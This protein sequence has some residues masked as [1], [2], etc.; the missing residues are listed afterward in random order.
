MYVVYELVIS[1]KSICSVYICHVSMLYQAALHSLYLYLF[2]LFPRYPVIDSDLRVLT[3][4][5][6]VF[7]VPGN[8]QNRLVVVVLPGQLWNKA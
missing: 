2:E 3:A 8:R 6:D 1:Y 5:D 4:R 7:V